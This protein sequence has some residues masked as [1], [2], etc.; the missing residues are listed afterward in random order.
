MAHQ[1]LASRSGALRTVGVLM[2]LVIVLA[3]RE[4]PVPGTGQRFSVPSFFCYRPFLALAVS[5]FRVPQVDFVPITK[6]D[7]RSFCQ[8]LTFLSFVPQTRCTV[9]QVCSTALRL[10]AVTSLPGERDIAAPPVTLPLRS[11]LLCVQSRNSL[12]LPMTVLRQLDYHAE[13]TRHV[14]VY[15]GTSTYCFSS[16]VPGC[17][18][19]HQEKAYDALQA[20]SREW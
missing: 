13:I 4:F 8:S 12:F 3:V 20:F 11:C 14:F 10:A 2:L 5:W 16:P 15:F 19:C 18:L 7:A 6:V 1:E 17:C 9:F